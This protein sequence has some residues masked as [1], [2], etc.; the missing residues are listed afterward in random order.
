MAS[1]IFVIIIILSFVAFLVLCE[2]YHKYPKF[3]QLADRLPK[4][5]INVSAVFFPWYATDI[6]AV[7]FYSICCLTVLYGFRK[8]ITLNKF[9]KSGYHLEEEEQSTKDCFLFLSVIPIIFSLIGDNPAYYISILLP[10]LIIDLLKLMM[11]ISV[12]KSILEGVM[13]KFSS[14]RI[15]G[16]FILIFTSIFIVNM[17][18]TTP[19]KAFM[20]SFLIS[21]MIILLEMAFWRGLENII[22]PIGGYFLFKNFIVTDVEGLSINILAFIITTVIAFYLKNKVR[23]VERGLIAAILCGLTIWHVGGAKWM[24]PIALMFIAHPFLVK[25]PKDNP[26]KYDAD[27]IFA[28]STTAFLWLLATKHLTEF[29]CYYCFI[30]GIIIHFM[31]ILLHRFGETLSK[32]AIIV[33]LMKSHLLP[34]LMIMPFYFFYNKVAPT[35]YS[36]ALYGFFITMIIGVIYLIMMQIFVLHN[37]WRAHLLLANVGSLAGLIPIFILR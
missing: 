20:I 31:M 25:M 23:L 9:L 29:N 32:F 5:F 30:L 24:L 37:R 33:P 21:S 34:Y 2:K 15:L 7:W 12:N 28:I 13:S 10:I 6:V 14:K 16:L 35:H 4:Q 17:N 26:N 18:L 1:F 22:I 11:M 19:A 3:A 8:F 27:A 36:L